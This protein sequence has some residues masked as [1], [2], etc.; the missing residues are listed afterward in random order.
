VGSHNVR[1]EEEIGRRIRRIARA[2][3]EKS[4]N[5][6]I[7]V[8]EL[9]RYYVEGKQKRDVFGVFWEINY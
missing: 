9:F 3:G 7:F 1:E 4:E 2:H 8:V 5:L 6:V